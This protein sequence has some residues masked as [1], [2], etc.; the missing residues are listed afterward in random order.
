VL[1]GTEIVLHVSAGKAVSVPSLTDLTL[2][3]AQ[4][5]LASAGLVAEVTEQASDTVLIGVVISQDPASGKIVTKGSTVRFVVSSGPATP[6][7]T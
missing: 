7:S 3:A 5:K 1:Q 4:A 6:P 2:D